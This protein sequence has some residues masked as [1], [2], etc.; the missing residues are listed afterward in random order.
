MVKYLQASNLK[1][2]V[3]VPTKDLG[4]NHLKET[5]IVSVGFSSK[6][7]YK[8]A[9]DLNVEIKNLQIPEVSENMQIYGRR[10]EEWLLL[11]IGKDISLYF[12]T[13]AFNKEVDII[14]IWT[15]RLSDEEIS[16]QSKLKNTFYKNRYKKF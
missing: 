15:N 5:S 13:E 9:K 7:I 14:N 12:F 2:I 6:H 16:N 3:V 10:D 11:E 1:D 8:S 4:F